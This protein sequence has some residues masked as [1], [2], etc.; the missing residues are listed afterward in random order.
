MDL[1]KGIMGM[2]KSKQLAA[3][4][5]LLGAFCIH[6]I[7][8]AIYRWNMI[9]GYVGTFYDINDWTPVGAPLSMFCVGVTMRLGYNLSGD[10][11]SLSIMLFAMFVIG[12]STMT[13]S[14]MPNFPS[15]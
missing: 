6:L 9:T 3:I 8:G 7:V 14:Y 1:F 15:K 12:A 4:G 11:G 2:A 13:A 10:K 5:G